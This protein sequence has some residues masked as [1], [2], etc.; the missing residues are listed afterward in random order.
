MVMKLLIKTAVFVILAMAGATFARASDLPKT[1]DDEFKKSESICRDV[2]SVRALKFNARVITEVQTK[3]DLVK[4]VRKSVDE[5]YGKAEAE[6]YIKAL[7]K[8]GLLEKELNLSDTMVKILEGQAAAHYDP[9]TKKC[10]LL[11]TD[12][13]AMMLDLVLSHELCHALQ[14]QH[15]N[16][17]DFAQKDIKAIRDNGDASAGKECLI[18]GD[19][20]FVMMAWMV[21]K[22][23]GVTDAATA[24]PMVAMAINMQGAMDYDTVLNMAESNIDQSLGSLTTSIKEMKDAP[25]FFMESLYAVYVQGAMMVNFVKTKGGWDAVNALY[26]NPPQST[27]Q[28]LHPEKLIGKR[29]VPVD[30]RMPELKQKL[31]GKWSL[32]EEDV[33]GELGT[34]IL[35][36]IWADKESRDPVAISAAAA[37][38]GGDRYYYWMNDETGKNLLVWKTVWD[39]PEDAG[40]F[41][42]SY[43]LL[44]SARFPKMKKAGQ[45]KAGDKFMYQIWEV[46]PGRFLKLVR[47]EEMVGVIDST[48][49]SCL[50]IIWK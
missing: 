36:E 17:H 25:R 19:A 30:V 13:D 21:M 3:A 24:D 5:Q 9:E 48:D 15:F 41:I 1:V 27:E 32:K 26:K 47:S 7:V 28:V 34:K 11:A 16:L 37:G 45:S 40:E 10:Y 2:E 23:G 35:F 42:T 50:D 8:M 6:W 12:M 46:E 39:S 14:D 49:R 4:F 29:D 20:T 18:E 22:Q 43:R 31:S 38:W 44:L 33:L